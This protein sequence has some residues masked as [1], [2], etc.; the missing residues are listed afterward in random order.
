MGWGA[1]IG[2]CHPRR[3]SAGSGKA[4][5]S[6]QGTEKEE[7]REEKKRKR[8][9]RE[10]RDRGEEGER[11]EGKR[12]RRGEEGEKGGRGRP[13]HGKARPWWGSLAPPPVAPGGWGAA[14]LP[15]SS[16]KTRRA[17]SW[18]CSPPTSSR[19]P[20]FSRARAWGPGPRL[21]RWPG[22]GPTG[23]ACPAPRPPGHAAPA[24]PPAPAAPTRPGTRP[25]TKGRQPGLQARPRRRNPLGAAPRPDARRP[26]RPAPR[27]GAA[28]GGP[29]SSPLWV[30]T[31]GRGPTTLS[32]GGLPKCG[33]RRPEHSRESVCWPWHAV[34]PG[35]IC[36]RHPIWPLES[37]RARRNELLRAAG[38][39]PSRKQTREQ[40][41]KSQRMPSALGLLRAGGPQLPV[42]GDTLL[43]L[44]G[45]G[46]VG[47]GM[48]DKG[49]WASGVQA[50]VLPFLRRTRPSLLGSR[51]YKHLW[52]QLWLGLLI[53][54]RR[55][56]HNNYSNNVLVGKRRKSTSV[57]S[58][59]EPNHTESRVG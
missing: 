6:Q 8:G 45:K 51:S 54:I 50:A 3:D 22:S 26:P 23:P 5:P 30:G 46:M 13:R 19:S 41:K 56:Y 39:A 43:R 15:G 1:R 59:R 58:T 55:F 7:K 4:T 27:P 29:G 18:T 32:Q 10:E 9:K 48:V 57:G 28:P 20:T 42:R 40:T 2:R 35:S 12:E 49:T 47:K 36:L 37:Q 33:F 52:V 11:G 38:A 25:L 31:R 53:N 17:P 24:R 21:T 34:D 16:W 44:R 14:Y